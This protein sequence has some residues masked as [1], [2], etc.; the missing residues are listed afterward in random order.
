MATTT[1]TD[2][3]Y[4]KIMKIRNDFSKTEI[5]KSGH[6]TFQHLKYLELADFIPTAITLCCKYGVYTHIDVGV[7]GF[8]TMIAV[9]TDNPEQ[10][11][12]YRLALPSLT[13]TEYN[14]TLKMDLPKD[15][16][17]QI[18]DTGKL[19]TYAR[20]YLYM[21]FLDIAVPD[22]V[23]AGK[24]SKNNHTP[25]ANK[26]TFNN[27]KRTMKQL[28]QEKQA[29][30]EEKQRQ[31]E[32]TTE[33]ETQTVEPRHRPRPLQTDLQ[34]DD[35]E[36]LRT[37]INKIIRI[38]RNEGRKPIRKNIWIKATECCKDGRIKPEYKDDL[39]KYIMTHCPE[40]LE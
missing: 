13:Q 20:R 18:Q 1:N 38:L 36:P 35:P 21:L 31:Q 19:E 40:E 11:V 14:K 22:T 8:A 6:N 30:I 7:D 37:I 28:H 16:T 32:E 12:Q 9:N 2:N 4:T 15:A 10:Y 3:I 29:K 33:Y 24:P 25:P 5:T 17:K 26:S 39:Q 23:D 34:I 27:P